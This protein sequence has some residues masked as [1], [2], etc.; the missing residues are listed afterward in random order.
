MGTKG[1]FGEIKPEAELKGVCSQSNQTGCRL[2]EGAAS[3]PIH[4]PRLRLGQ[5]LPRVYTTTTQFNT[6]QSQR[7]SGV[8][9]S[10]I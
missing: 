2:L 1:S 5:W 6:N 3:T 10:A 7:R 9:R 8:V 4:Q